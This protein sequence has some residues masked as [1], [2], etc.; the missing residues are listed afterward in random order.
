MVLQGIPIL[1]DQCIGD[2]LQYINSAFQ[3]LCANA[4][5]FSSTV[6]GNFALNS[7]VTSLS[8]T[9]DAKFIPKPASASAQQV[10]TYNGS[11]TTW[12]ASAAPNGSTG[13]TSA[14][15]WVNFDGTLA[16]PSSVGKSYNVS[17]ITKNGTGDYTVNFAT[18]MANANY[19]VAGIVQRF[20][21]PWG[22]TVSP[23]PD[24]TSPYDPAVAFNLS[25]FRAKCQDYAGNHEDGGTISL[26]FFG[27]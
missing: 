19:A 15:A 10:L 6:N 4:E 5:T 20:G 21:S 3:T 7:T 8:S 13:P 11:T 26:I 17:S 1:E 2:S 25:T 9:V 24:A 16:T 14:K 12:V 27:N 22:Y 18:A 23:Y